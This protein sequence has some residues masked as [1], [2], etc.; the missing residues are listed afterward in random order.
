[1]IK[2][3]RSLGGSVTDEDPRLE[4]LGDSDPGRSWMLMKLH[5]RS[6]Q[7]AVQDEIKMKEQS[8]K[9]R[10]ALSCNW[11]NTNRSK[12]SSEWLGR[13]QISASHFMP[14][15]ANKIT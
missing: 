8:E 15:H 12:T 6:C 13:K 2:N 5:A 9:R 1:M 10:R 4:P 11:E 3:H 14:D 7:H